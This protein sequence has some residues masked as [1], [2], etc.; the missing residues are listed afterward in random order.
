MSSLSLSATH[1][2]R[3]V[4]RADRRSCG[5]GWLRLLRID[6]LRGGGLWLLP[7]AIFFA[8][9]IL[10]NALTPGV[11]LWPEI[12]GTVSTISVPLTILAAGIG[13]FSGAREQRRGMDELTAGTAMATWQRYLSLATAAFLWA[14]GLYL[15]FALPLVTYGGMFATWGGPEIG[16]ITVV[17]PM[18]ALASVFGVLIG[19]LVRDRTT[20]V[21]A[22]A[23]FLLVFV[24]APSVEP[25]TR[26]L[27]VLNL[28]GWF[29]TVMED[30]ASRP[31][32][33]VAQLAWGIGLTGILVGLG[34]W[35][36]RRTIA[37]ALVGVLSAVVALGG[38]L[39][40]VDA[41]YEAPTSS[42]GSA[43]VTMTMPANAVCND[44][45][46]VEVCVHSAYERGLPAMTEDVNAFLGPVAG[47][48]G[49]V[50]QVYLS[51][52]NVQGGGWDPDRDHAA[53]SID[54][55]WQ[56]DVQLAIARDLWPF[57]FYLR[58][59]PEGNATGDPVQYVVM[60]ALARDIGVDEWSEPFPHILG[61]PGQSMEDPALDVEIHRFAALSQEEQRAWFTANWDSLSR[62]E[63]TLEDLP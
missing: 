37:S 44:I 35:W 43:T 20:P 19:R 38:A 52:G 16:V 51:S 34:I 23:I 46:P 2:G 15:L 58:P 49:V 41:G 3:H 7:A 10:R 28:N 53:M 12:T 63:L 32:S 30:A 1:E 27:G 21:L 13:A 57:S 47:L 33:V 56:N 59:M 6:I 29:H 60:T 5:A 45:R 18:M 17:I 9:M 8:W 50:D 55:A 4:Y 61:A 62:G 11:A 48:E 39:A 40:I 26:P 36:E 22:I 42:G 31:F 25:S 14:L 24:V 54:L